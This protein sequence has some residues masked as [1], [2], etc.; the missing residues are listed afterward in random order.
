MAESGS[1]FLDT[2][3]VLVALSQLSN[4]TVSVNYSVI[5]GSASRDEDYS[6]SEGTL[7]FSPGEKYRYFPIFITNDTFPEVDETI[8]ISLSNPV[9]A[10]LGSK[11]KYV[12]TIQDNDNRPDSLGYIDILPSGDTSIISNSTSNKGAE[13]TIDIGKKAGANWRGL[14]KFDFSQVPKGALIKSAY[15]HANVP[16]SID[17]GDKK[18]N[19]SIYRL[20]RDWTEKEA[21]WNNSASLN[22]WASPGADDLSQDRVGTASGQTNTS[23]AAFLEDFNPRWDLTKDVQGMINGDVPNYGW[24]MIG[25]ETGSSDDFFRVYAREAN[26]NYIIEPHLMITYSVP[27]ISRGD[28]NS[29]NLINQSDF[30][31]LKNDF[32]KLTANLTNPKSDI[33]A[34]GQ[35]TVKDA[36]ILMSGWK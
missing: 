14:F 24:L 36:G 6:L 3:Y 7:S 15:L 22:T 20:L 1:E 23:L 21:T 33:D 18:I 13:T 10:N 12:Y 30:D 25:P 16:Y 19:A 31:I 28:L 5:G 2:N 9:N 8:Q 4:K 34:D 32:L 35:C 29:D 26:K 27:T 17:N 11:D